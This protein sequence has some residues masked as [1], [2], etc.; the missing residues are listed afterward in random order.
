MADLMLS[1]P[2]RV[3]PHGSD[4]IR[5][6]ATLQDASEVLIDWPHAKRG[7]FYQAAREKIEAA[8]TNN[9]GAAQA[10]EAFTA[11]C[12]HAGLLVR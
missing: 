1:T 11:L 12:D 9:E 7:P 10:Q 8:L 2:L 3:K 4:T 6:V 5:E